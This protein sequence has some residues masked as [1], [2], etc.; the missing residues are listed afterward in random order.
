MLGELLDGTK[1]RLPKGCVC[2]DHNVPHW[3][4][5]D[6]LWRARN[7]EL[8]SG[9]GKTQEQHY[10][11]LMGAAKEEDA[12]L[13]SKEAAFRAAGIV[14]LI[15]EPCDELTDIQRTR[16]SQRAADLR[17]PELPAPSPYLDEATRVRVE[18]REAV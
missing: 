10:Y 6:R 16:L 3:V 1:T 12:R 14:R 9:E 4:H 5:M 15:D 2:C 13:R 8:T 7:R 18:A 17:G 11:G